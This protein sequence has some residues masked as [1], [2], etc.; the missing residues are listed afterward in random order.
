[1]ITSLKIARYLVMPF[2]KFQNWNCMIEDIFFYIGSSVAIN[3]E[4]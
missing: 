3:H 4:F 1:M 2:E